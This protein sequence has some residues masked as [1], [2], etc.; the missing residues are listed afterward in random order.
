LSEEEETKMAEGPLVHHYARRLHSALAGK[1]TEVEFGIKKLRGRGAE[2]SG[3]T[4]S[5]VEALGKQFRIFFE[6]G[7][8]VLVHLLMWGSW[9]IY[10]KDEEWEKPEKRARL[11][12]RSE[13]RVVVAFSAP[14][15]R[16]Y[17]TAEAL[18]E[19]RWGNSGP[20][21]LRE[22]YARSAAF[23]SIRQEGDRPI[24][25]VIM[26]QTVLAGVGNI[27]RNEILFLSGVH[28]GRRVSSL[29]DAELQDILSHTEDLMHR[30]LD[31]VG[32]TKEWSV[33][34]QRS[35]QPCPECGTEI[36]FSRQDDR[37]TYVCPN[38]QG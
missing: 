22:D 16:L 33:V 6:T 3:A 11:I 17:E 24:G 13:D 19:S 12:I 31:G 10:G 37:V 34:Y 35:G 30:W 2:L 28:P 7:H 4:V 8:I 15:I 25:V 1:T 14:I 38:C 36:E 29:E 18:Q 27:L 5:R 9:G 26:D 21:P 20:D 23:R 32:G